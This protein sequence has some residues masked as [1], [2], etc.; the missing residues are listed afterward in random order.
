MGDFLR[1]WFVWCYLYLQHVFVMMYLVTIPGLL[2]CGFLSVRYRGVIQERLLRGG[3]GLRTVLYAIALGMTIPANRRESLEMASTLITNGV[4][5]AIALAYFIASR[6]LGLYLLLL[7]TVLIGL[8][9]GLGVLLGGL[10]MIFLTV[11]GTSFIPFFPPPNKVTSYLKPDLQE[12]LATSWHV[13][14]LSRRGWW[15]VVKDI[16]HVFT[17]LGL[18]SLGGL[19]LGGLILALDMRKVWPLPFWLGDEG[20]GPAIATALLGPLLSFISFSSPLG[21]LIVVASIWKTW[22]LAYPGII[23]FALASSLYP[24][25][26]HSVV[27]L[28]GPR[29]GWYVA[30]V[31]Y[32]S[33]AFGGLTVL[34]LFEVLG[35]E[36]THVPWFEPL[37]KN[38]IMV[39]PFTMLGTGGMG[40]M[41]KMTGM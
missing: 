8:E 26:L 36:V 40:L 28:F 4:P 17:S 35:I 23:S 18:P 41:G 24:S 38:I 13:L 31:H 21:N 20:P 29:T 2:A 30:A 1:D 7:F 5:S 11:I 10:V 34:G 39:L 9:F 27:N 32:F 3:G 19:L 6:T 25:N 22:T 37:V 16:G 14:L 12:D 33:A 15:A